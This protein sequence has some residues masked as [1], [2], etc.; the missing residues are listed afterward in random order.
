MLF[1]YAGYELGRRRISIG[2]KLVYENEDDK[3]GK[4]RFFSK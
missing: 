3:K 1:I 2:S 4:R